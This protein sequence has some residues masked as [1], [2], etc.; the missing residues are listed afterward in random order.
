MKQMGAVA[1]SRAGLLDDDLWVM[2][3]PDFL[4]TKALVTLTTTSNSTSVY[5]YDCNRPHSNNKMERSGPF[6]CACF[7]LKV[8]TPHCSLTQQW[9]VAGA[10]M[11]CFEDAL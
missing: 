6:P 11:L 7:F 4:R 1:T 5:C 2:S 3:C 9:D 8:L 10:F